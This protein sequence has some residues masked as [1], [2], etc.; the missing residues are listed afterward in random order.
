MSRLAALAAVMAIASSGTAGARCAGGG[1]RVR[2]AY[3][4]LLLQ[5]EVLRQCRASGI[6]STAD[7]RRVDARLNAARRAATRHGWGGV[8]AAGDRALPAR[9]AAVDTSCIVGPGMSAAEGRLMHRR[10]F[11]RALAVLARRLACRR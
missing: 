1:A 10:D 4:D 11:D 2:A 5:H 3:D 8:L 6:V 9:V 7:Q